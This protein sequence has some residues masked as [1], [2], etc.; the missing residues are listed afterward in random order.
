ML[1]T[2]IVLTT[3]FPKHKDIKPLLKQRDD[4]QDLE[5]ESATLVSQEAMVF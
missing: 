2:S 5:G 1:V 4:E 3:A